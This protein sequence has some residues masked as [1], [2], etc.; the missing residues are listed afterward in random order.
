MKRVM[1][2]KLFLV[3]ALVALVTAG[4]EREEFEATAVEANQQ[5][6]PE[7]SGQAVDKSDQYQIQV[8]EA[9]H[10]AGAQ[11]TLLVEVLPG[12]NLE[13]NLEFPWAL[14]LPQVEGLEF[15]S[16]EL[17]RDELDLTLERAQLPVKFQAA[18]A[19]VYEVEAR[20]DFS[21]CNDDRCD[22][23]RDEPLSFTVRVQ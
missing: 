19:G 1:K 13:I 6:A 22:I 5:G 20:A 4:C 7:I 2:L 12:P 14:R 10:Q 17:K 15:Q 9:E 18:Q 11:E 3:L 8:V 16:P 23:L 21:V